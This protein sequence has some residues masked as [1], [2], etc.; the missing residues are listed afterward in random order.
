MWYLQYE[1]IIVAEACPEVRVLFINTQSPTSERDLEYGLQVLDNLGLKN[2]TVAKANV[3][4]E[5]F[6]DGME[7]VGISQEKNQNIFHVLSQD[8]FK[9][10]PLKQACPSVKCLLSGVRRGQTKERDHFKFIES[11]HHPSKAHP[12]LDWSDD[13]CLEFMRMKKIPPHPEL[14]SLLNDITTKTSNV[15]ISCPEAKVKVKSSLRSRR[16]SRGAG[17]ECG[18][19]V[20]KEIKVSGKKHIPVPSLPNIVVGKMKCRFCVAAKNLLSQS[21]IDYIEAPVHLFEH[22]IP[23]GTTT[24]PVVYLNKQMIGGYDNLCEHLGAEDTLNSKSE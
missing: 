9:L 11:D 15:K 3:T 22:L 18:I 21:G 24:V 2:F 16:G 4:R 13:Q 6:R 19:H 12:I 1:I 20:Q 8:V 14:T 17:K 5:D 7:E 10:T 23:A